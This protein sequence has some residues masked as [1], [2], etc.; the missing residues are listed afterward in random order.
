MKLLR[1][2]LATAAV[3]VA[4]AGGAQ[5]Q[6]GCPSI[7]DRAILTAAQWNACF[8]AKQDANTPSAPLP[9]NKG[10][11]GLNAGTSGGVPY[12]S[13]GSTMAS[14]PALGA[15]GVVIG[16][17]AGAAPTALPTGTATQ[18][19]HGGSS[20]AMGAV[21]LATDVSG[22]AGTGN[23][24]TGKSVVA[25]NGVLEEVIPVQI[26]TAASKVFATADLQYA[27]RRS[28]SG[29]AMSD[30][31]PAAAA[32]GMVNGARIIIANV[33]A[34]ATDTVTA[35]SGTTIDGSSTIAIPAG[36]AIAFVY[37][38]PSAIW[39][40]QFNTATAAIGPASATSGNLPSFADTTGKK[41]A[42]S[43]VAASNVVT[44]SGTQSVTGQKNFTTATVGGGSIGSDALEVTGSTTHN[45]AV[46]VSSPSA[47]ALA[48]GANGS[49]NP[50]FKVDASTAS[51]VNGVQVKGGVAGGGAVISTVS[52][53]TNDHLYID[54]KGTG[55]V[56]IA[57]NSSGKI[58]LSRATTLAAITGLV[59][60]LQVNASGD[61][62]G[63]GT[64]C[65]IPSAAPGAVTAASTTDLSTAA[66]IVQTVSG[67]TTITSFGSGANLTRTLMF[68]GT[69][70]L[71]YNATTLKTPTGANIQACPG[72]V[73]TLVSDGSGNWTVTGFTPFGAPVSSTVG[74]S[75]VGTSA[76]SITSINIGCGKWVVT[77]NA[78]EDGSGAPAN[79]YFGAAIGTTINSYTGT[80]EPRTKLYGAPALAGSSTPIGYVSFAP[81][82]FTG[83][84][85][86]TIFLTVNARSNPDNF[87]GY[88]RAERRFLVPPAANDNFEFI[89]KW[90]SR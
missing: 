84:G 31:F 81:V 53:S 18:V 45:G 66:N 17:G 26:S 50:A 65:G 4:L 32:A 77:A 86:Q 61:V 36:R 47:S 25:S 56:V 2:S 5:A 14:S 70:L 42:D 83:T 13:S 38:Q 62:T 35:G 64:G 80:V 11:T 89:P 1:L 51:V 52:S 40:T 34:T 41:L 30:T 67:N 10:G 24:P 63:A 22:V 69:P 12:Y 58:T 85:A 59:Q 60:C 8:A 16:G 43:G 54:A 78:G 79:D 33:D 55:Q 9:V 48:V 82:E 20:P 28:N 29:S 75:G 90:R 39:R 21:N 6:S 37:D 27:T 15:G 88:I 49:T 71:T 87:Y 68:T 72:D 46:V 73:A 44:L 74:P 7:V 23:L 3:L 57:A 76:T 19:L